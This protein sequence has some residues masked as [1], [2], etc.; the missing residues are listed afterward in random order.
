MYVGG[1]VLLRGRAG[2]T[3][4][5]DNRQV[6]RSLDGPKITTFQP[7]LIRILFLLMDYTD[8]G[9]RKLS[10]LSLKL[11]ADARCR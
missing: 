6:A 3:F 4:L 11:S 7:S 10:A 5:P 8:H 2:D 1:V 9:K